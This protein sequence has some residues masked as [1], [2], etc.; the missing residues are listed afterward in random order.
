MSADIPSTPVTSNE[1]EVNEDK[2]KTTKKSHSDG[3]EVAKKKTKVSSDSGVAKKKTKASSADS[4]IP[5]KKSVPGDVEKKTKVQTKTGKSVEGHRTKAEKPQGPIDSKTE[6]P[7]TQEDVDSKTEQPKTQEDVDSKTE[8]P[9]TQ[10]EVDSKTEQPKTQE[11]VDSKTEQPQDVSS[12][13][14]PKTK[15]T[16]RKRTVVNTDADRPIKRRTKMSTFRLCQI[17]SGAMSFWVVKV[18]SEKLVW[19]TESETWEEALSKLAWHTVSGES[20]Y[21]ARLLQ[22]TTGVEP[23]TYNEVDGNRLSRFALKDVWLQQ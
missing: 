1:V 9:K 8:Q 13:Q 18:P 19:S 17:K 12:D 11:E 7:K 21:Y 10:E 3:S 23:S 16:R 22:E 20:P 5:K 14:K 15:T 6:Q 4:G 2:K